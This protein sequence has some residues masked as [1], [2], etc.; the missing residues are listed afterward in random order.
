[1]SALGKVRTKLYHKQ[2]MQII[3]YIWF[4]IFYNMGMLGLRCVQT[5]IYQGRGTLGLGY[6]ITWNYQEII[7]GHKFVSNKICK[8]KD[9]SGV[10]Y[11]STKICYDQDTIEFKNAQGWYIL[12]IGYVSSR[13]YQ[14]YYMPK[15][16]H[17]M[18]RI[19]QDWGIFDLGYIRITI[20][21]QHDIT[22]LVF[23]GTIIYHI[24]DR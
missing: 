17:I 15:Y 7:S 9:I 21:L 22:R 20:Y 11:V 8:D 18:T 10:R 12:L 3:G 16:G 6:V 19:K 5:G 14:V 23:A 4:T 2:D 1:M 24:M 13:M